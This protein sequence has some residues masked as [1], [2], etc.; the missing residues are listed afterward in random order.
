VGIGISDKAKITS[1]AAFSKFTHG[2]MLEGLLKGSEKVNGYASIIPLTI[3]S[4]TV[5]DNVMLVG[6]AAG[7]VKATTGGGII[8]GCSCAKILASTV[9][10]NIKKG[11]PL[12]A[13]EKEWRRRYSLDL[14]LHNFMHSYYSNLK[15]SNF[16]VFLKFLKVFG[17][18]DFF[19]KYGDM[20]KPSLMLKR[21]F[22]RGLA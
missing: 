11:T 15:V 22:L 16:E 17:A 8:F 7:Q 21:F 13:Y 2:G 18:E 20:D 9:N 14:N 3:R 12:A 6:D 5:K 1:T 10:S 19:S 4:S